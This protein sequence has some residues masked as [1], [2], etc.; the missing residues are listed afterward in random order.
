MSQPQ[1]LGRH[2]IFTYESYCYNVALLKP[3]SS[4]TLPAHQVPKYPRGSTSPFH[5]SDLAVS[6]TQP[7]PLLVRDQI[8]AHNRKTPQLRVTRLL[9]RPHSPPY[10]GGKTLNSPSA[11]PCQ[12]H[13]TTSSRVPSDRGLAC[14]RTNNGKI[15]EWRNRT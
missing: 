14:A 10:P 9:L 1:S 7:S 2:S 6:V 15:V 13:R 3:P 5:Q 8:A 11:C 4:Q 12:M